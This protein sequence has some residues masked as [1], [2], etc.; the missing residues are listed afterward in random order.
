MM[1][2]AL[3]IVGAAITVGVSGQTT[4]LAKFRQA[5]LRSH[6][7]L[8][9]RHSAPAFRLDDR[10]NR[11]AQDWADHLA[12]SGTFEHSGGKY[13]ENLYGVSSSSRIDG[14]A[15]AAGAT[16]GWYG[17]SAQYRYGSG[18]SS[19]TGHFTQLV[20][21]SS[22]RLGCGMARGSNGSLNTVYVVC[23]YDPPGNVTN[24]FP[25]NVLPPGSRG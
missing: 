14:P 24:E 1:S 21:K 18:F 4:D 22:T 8:R 12:A 19:A 10:L 16:D 6:N 15:A 3:L 20:W 25:Q 13:G 9:A 7:E 17:E 5:I 11:Y 2:R 23:S